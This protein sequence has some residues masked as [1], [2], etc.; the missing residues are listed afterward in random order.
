MDNFTDTIVA[1]ATPPGVGGVG[2]VRVSG[3]LTE[4][5]AKTMLGNLPQ[6]RTATYKSFRDTSGQK[7]DSGLVLYF[8]APLSFTGESVLEIQG[9]GGPYLQSLIID[10]ILDLG[11]RYAKPG[12]FSQRAFLNGKL[13]LVQAEAIPD[14]INSGTKQ[15][16]RA[17]F[18]SLT[19]VFSNY[20]DVLSK[21]L[22]KLRIHIEAAIDFPEEEIDFLSDESLLNRI[23]DCEQAFSDLL[24]KTEQGT[25]LRDGFQVIIIGRP[26]VGKSSLL[27]FL[28]EQDSAIVTEMAGTTR[29]I[30][31][32]QIDIDGLSVEL[33]DTAGLRDNPEMVEA[34][35]IRRA[36]KAM[37]TADALIVVQDITDPNSAINNDEIPNGL[38]TIY[39]QNKIDL[40]KVKPKAMENYIQISASTGEGVKQLRHQ[41]RKIAGYEN[42]GEGAFTAR[43][44][45]I[46]S[47]K[48][49]AS[50]FYNGKTVFYEKNAGEL[51]AEE[52]RLSHQALGEIVGTVSSDDLLGHIF[53]DFCIGK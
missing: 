50:H 41:I 32:E 45:H 11:A 24:N 15:A 12:E 39:V 17:A 53:S 9:H 6:P 52:L 40:C 31:R 13:D 49:A 48:K 42:Q 44:R 23:T 22:L 7:I 4:N 38:Q 20:V 36:R 25:L 51:L 43:K 29:D 27:N 33:V 8:P 47:L 26:N 1:P 21:K 2:I 5:I 16:A 37:E 46:Q 14:L 28:S 10:V 35:G 19:G 30:L 18:R 3:K 34:E